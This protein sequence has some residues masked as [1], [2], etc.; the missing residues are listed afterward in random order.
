[1]RVSAAFLV[2]ALFAGCV[3]PPAASQEALTGSTRLDHA[4]VQYAVE[5]SPDTWVTM[6]LTPADLWTPRLERVPGV[7][8]RLAQSP[9]SSTLV[10]GK[11][12]GIAQNAP[13]NVQA[14]AV[15]GCDAPLWEWAGAEGI[16]GSPIFYSEP[17]GP[18]PAWLGTLLSL[19][20]SQLPIPDEGARSP[21]GADQESAP[22][23]HLQRAFL[24]GDV[25]LH[26]AAE[27][28]SWLAT[29]TGHDEPDA[30]L[31]AHAWDDAVRLYWLPNDP[32]PDR[33]LQGNTAWRRVMQRNEGAP[34]PSCQPRPERAIYGWGPWGP[35]Q[36]LPLPVSLKDIMDQIL[37]NPMLVEFQKFRLEHPDAY[38]SELLA[39]PPA[40]TEAEATGQW[41]LYFGY[42]GGSSGPGVVCKVRDSGQEWPD[43]IACL[44]GLGEW[45][46]LDR[47]L[48]A[49]DWASVRV[50]DFLVPFTFMETYEPGETDRLVSFSFHDP[51][52]GDPR[53]WVP[54]AIAHR[55]HTDEALSL[56]FD[57]KDPDFV[58]VVGLGL[59]VFVDPH[60]PQS[61]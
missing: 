21:Q 60:D 56:Y 37:A 11:L 57:P 35:E 9:G 13:M 1:M 61:R 14:I 59:D 44:P 52:E 27:R 28:G 12:E 48:P 33:V 46:S 19:R 30:L 23:E 42:P 58:G 18:R 7:V 39:Y 34:W 55:L 51:V 8:A 40:Q 16:S 10:E 31:D 2:V 17:N 54:M 43:A 38:L 24:H 49:V 29:W 3:E 26:V 25:V 45:R 5:G 36:E 15:D 47:S 41:Q 22:P 4:F 32:F 50:T 53:P 6:S 20:R